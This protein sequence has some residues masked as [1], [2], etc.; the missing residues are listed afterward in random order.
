MTH[1]FGLWQSLSETD[2]LWYVSKVPTTGQIALP[3]Y[4]MQLFCNSPSQVLNQIGG[5]SRSTY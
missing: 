2:P 1:Q 5:K 4:C 3:A